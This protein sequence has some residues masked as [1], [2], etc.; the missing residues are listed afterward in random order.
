MRKESGPPASTANEDD[1]RKKEKSH[2]RAM[3]KEATVALEA[4]DRLR[5]TPS[6]QARLCKTLKA[7]DD[8]KSNEKTPHLVRDHS[9]DTKVSSEGEK[10]KKPSKL[11]NT[12][13]VD[14][15]LQKESS[16]AASKDDA[17]RV[18]G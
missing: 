18:P 4:S 5:V 9:A 6:R 17:R 12:V 7:L 15:V 2:R 16:P 8:A 3:K 1:A 11:R 14:D 13:S 10:R